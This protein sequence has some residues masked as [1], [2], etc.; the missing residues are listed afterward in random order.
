MKNLLSRDVRYRFEYSKQNF[1]WCTLFLLVMFSFKLIADIEYLSMDSIS[2][3]HII[4]NLF[5]G[6]DFLDLQNI[7][8]GKFDIPYIWILFQ[9]LPLIVVG[10][11]TKNDIKKNGCYFI[12]RVNNYM[13][14]VG[15]KSATLLLH[16]CAIWCLWFAFCGILSFLIVSLNGRGYE[17][18]DFLI[19]KV[20]LLQVL[21]TFVTLLFFEMI[22]LVFS[23]VVSYVLVFGCV[24]S[25]LLTDIHFI[26]PCFTNLSRWLTLDT[27]GELYPSFADKYYTVGDFLPVFIVVFILI[28]A[29]ELVFLKKFNMIGD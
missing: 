17:V 6:T 21:V 2:F 22:A 29:L 10:A 12:P 18:F 24:I 11:A 8:E 27:T 19:I 28:H 14:F 26:I 20:A 7:S 13:K 5:A 1:V 9:V 4:T 15:V 25:A 16:V 3:S 23:E